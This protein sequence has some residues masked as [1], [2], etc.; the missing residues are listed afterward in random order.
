MGQFGRTSTTSFYAFKSNAKSEITVEDTGVISGNLCLGHKSY[1]YN[2]PD[3]YPCGV[4]IIYGLIMISK[5]SFT[6]EEMKTLQVIAKTL[7]DSL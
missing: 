7:I 2:T 5:D 3:S 6:E 4:K 1:T